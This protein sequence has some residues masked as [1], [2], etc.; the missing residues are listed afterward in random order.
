MF[1]RNVSTVVVVVR[2]SSGVSLQLGDTER[3]DPLAGVGL[4]D[5]DLFILQPLPALREAI[6]ILDFG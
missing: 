2:R 3:C 4:E 6:H 1:Q 5:G